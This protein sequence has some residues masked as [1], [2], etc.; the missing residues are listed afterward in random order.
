MR[1]NPI[2]QLLNIIPDRG[3]FL[4]PINF[5]EAWAYT[6]AHEMCKKEKGIIIT[7]FLHQILIYS[8]KV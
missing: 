2:I 5:I 3:H 7:W 1:S 8:Y 4:R 6:L